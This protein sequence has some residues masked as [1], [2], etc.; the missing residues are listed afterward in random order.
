MKAGTIRRLISRTKPPL[1][2][3]TSDGKVVYVDHPESVLVSPGLIVIARGAN[4]T[5]RVLKDDELIFL[6][7]DHI[8]RVERTRRKPLRRVA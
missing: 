6:N 2:L 8:V 7:P 3:F 5:G 4:G 1:N